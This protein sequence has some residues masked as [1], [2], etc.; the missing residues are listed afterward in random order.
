VGDG[1]LLTGDGHCTDIV[2]GLK[3]NMIIAHDNEGLHVDVLKV[4]HHGSEH[5]LTEE[6]ARQITADHY[7]ICGNGRHENPDLRVLDAIVASR[8]GSSGER[9]NN[10][11]ASKPFHIWFNCSVKFLTK[12]IAQMK[13]E[14]RNTDEY[15][16]AKEHFAKVEE[17][18]QGHANS[19]KGK[20]T[21]HY[22]VDDHLEL[23]LK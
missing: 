15:Q 3:H 5:N 1:I 19:S 17:C 16:K 20:L 22:L 7:V 9:S 8:L 2:K 4:Q 21:L 10:A 23:A 11:K 6:F 18:M 12:Q 13:K 14:R